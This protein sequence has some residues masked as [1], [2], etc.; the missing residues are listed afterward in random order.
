[1]ASEQ[2]TGQKSDQKSDQKSEVMGGLEVTTPSEREIRMT[3]TFD[4]PRRLV[5]R[6]WTEPELC[7]RWFGPERYPL[8]VCE[9]DL[10]VGGEY[11]YVWRLK[12]GA[13]M[14][15]RGV[16]R[17]VA[18]PERLVNTERFDDAWYEGEALV[19]TELVEAAGRTK[20][21]QTS[22]FASQKG[23]D[24]ALQSPGMVG[25]VVES[26]ARLDALL[27]AGLNIEGDIAVVR[28]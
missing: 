26:Y 2:V 27:R 18:A 24:M 10:R 16:Y 11:R 22:L 25:G 4:A 12:G 1:M 13:E 19:T 5:W 6:A 21:V 23:R 28:G 14:T 3:R 17:E 20:V 7:K 8:I 9:I 15:M